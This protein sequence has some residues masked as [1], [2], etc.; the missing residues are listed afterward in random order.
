VW[1]WGEEEDSKLVLYFELGFPRQ[2]HQSLYSKL[3]PILPL[4]TRITAKSKN[5]RTVSMEKIYD[6]NYSDSD[7]KLVVSIGFAFRIVAL[8]VWCGVGCFGG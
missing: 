3:F 2:K 7:L 1:V 5:T 6:P 8:G 4:S